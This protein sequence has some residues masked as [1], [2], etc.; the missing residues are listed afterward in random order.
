MESIYAVATIMCFR[1]MDGSH[2][3]PLANVSTIQSA[4]RTASEV[5]DA[6]MRRAPE[7]LLAR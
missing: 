6:G 2:Q 5:M 4:M 1:Y 3:R 7:R